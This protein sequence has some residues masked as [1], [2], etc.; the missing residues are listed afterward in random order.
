M[1]TESSKS[2][3]GNG[4]HTS[5]DRGNDLLE[6][7]LDLGDN[8]LNLDDQSKDNLEVGLDK[9]TNISLDTLEG[10]NDVVDDVAEVKLEADD[11]LLQGLNVGGGSGDELVC[12]DRVVSVSSH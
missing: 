6:E 8:G 1:L 4:E 3:K 9:G 7:E 5:A 10:R 2:G 12:C 11:G